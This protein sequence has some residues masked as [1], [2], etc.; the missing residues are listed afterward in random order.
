MEH[1]NILASTV[2]GLGQITL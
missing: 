1:T 2:V